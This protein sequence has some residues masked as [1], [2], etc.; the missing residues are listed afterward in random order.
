MTA[1]LEIPNASG[2]LTLSWDPD[3]PGS[4]A[5]ARQEFERLKAAGYAFF[6]SPVSEQPIKRLKDAAFAQAG[7]LDVRLVREFQPRART[8]AVRQLRGG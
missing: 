8:L 4:D 6:A 3:V 1:T 7:T 5:K 2:H